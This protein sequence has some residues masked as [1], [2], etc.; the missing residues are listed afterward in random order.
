MYPKVLIAFDG[1]P[2][3]LLALEHL[4]A[5]APQLGVRE[6]HAL[7]MHERVANEMVTGKDELVEENGQNGEHFNAQK[8]RVRTVALQHRTEIEF[9][10][11]LSHHRVRGII[12]HARQG[13]FDLL[14][15][16]SSGH[17]E[18]SGHLFGHTVDL[19]LETAPCSVLVIK[20]T[21]AA[22]KSVHAYERIV[23]GFDQ[24]RSA[25]LALHHATAL[26]KSTKADVNAVWAADTP[27]V[28]ENFTTLT[29]EAATF[30]TPT[31]WEEH[32][33]RQENLYH[34]IIEP[35]IEQE[36]REERTEIAGHMVCGDAPDVLVNEARNSYADLIVLGHH[37]YR[38]LW[39]RLFG[40]TADR[41]YHR[42]SCDVLVV[43]EKATF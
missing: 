36:A 10:S 42:A 21:V 8:A 28:R 34:A 17:S 22:S 38:K 15:V 4:A 11:C 33:H 26:A 7:W 1:S 41:V 5:F 24:S 3:S 9:H 39:Y 6:S 35:G 37:N 14:V 40:G 32:R 31:Q 23:V 43:R 30:F 27:F 16:G 29:P 18:L 13:D 2:G 12:D 19:L 25:Q 20:P